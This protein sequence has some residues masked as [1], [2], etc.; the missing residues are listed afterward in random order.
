MS[1]PSMSSIEWIDVKLAMAQPG[2]LDRWVN[3]HYDQKVE[4]AK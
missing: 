2:F 4:Q 3:L 1:V